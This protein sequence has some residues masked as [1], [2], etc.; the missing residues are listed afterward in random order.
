MT[1]SDRLPRR[2]LGRTGRDVT[3]FGLG[4]EGVLRSY[5][6][7][8]EA[9]KVIQRAL[10]LGVNYFDSAPAYAGCLDYYG[11]ALGERRKDVFLASK[12]ADRTRDGSLQILDETLRRLRS[13]YL[14][15]WQLHDIRTRAD[16]KEIFSES[17]AIHALTQARADG[18]VRHLGITGHH[19]PALLADALERFDFDTVL[20]PLN[21]ADVHRL[22]FLRDV[23]PLA[24]AKGTAVIAM[25]VY[26]AGLLAEPGSACGTRDALYYALSLEGVA[27]AIIGCRTPQEVEENAAAVQRFTP[28]SED[29]RRELERLHSDKRWTPYK[30][31]MGAGG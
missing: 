20:I 26:S 31:G 19:D 8:P 5:G 25:K 16:L 21:C 9:R 17:G 1:Q 29:R 28:L 22:S 3:L 13:D 14:D 27:C 23:V 7:E 4:G 12:T 15:L 30:K 2:P 11:A 6:Q 24:R 18:R 10:D